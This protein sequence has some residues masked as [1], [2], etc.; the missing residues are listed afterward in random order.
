M[1][2]IFRREVEGFKTK[3]MKFALA[4]NVDLGVPSIGSNSFDPSI[5]FS[6]ARYACC[7]RVGKAPFCESQS[8]QNP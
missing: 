7:D 8:S 6:I 3:L 4:V 2:N 5:D 1:K